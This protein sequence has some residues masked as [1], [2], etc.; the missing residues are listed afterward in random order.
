MK[1]KFIWC[2]LVLIVFGISTQAQKIN[3]PK[4]CRTLLDKNFKG[5]KIVK[6]GIKEGVQGHNLIKGDWNGDGK[7]DYAILINHG[8]VQ[9][10]SGD[11]EPTAWTIAFVKQKR[12]YLFYKLDGGDSIGLMKK[13]MRDYNYE[14]G[15]NFFYN[16]DAIFVGIEWSGSSYIWRKGKFMRFATSD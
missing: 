2:A 6:V 16:N 11:Y 15:K 8:K 13:G 5:W 12:G 9:L 10:G 1:E 7:R 4:N 14:T 3:L